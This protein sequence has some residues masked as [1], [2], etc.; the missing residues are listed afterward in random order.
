MPHLHFKRTRYKT[1]SQNASNRIEYI[2]GQSQ[3]Q[4][5][6]SQRPG[7]EDLV[8]V[9]THNLP[10]WAASAHVYFQAAEQYE[11]ANGVAFEEFK[12]TLPVELTTDQNKALAE[13][14]IKV[15][16]GDRLPC[17]Y[18]FHNPKT[19][20]EARDQPHLHLLISGRMT[21]STDEY[22]R[23]VAQHFK[24]WNGKEPGQ[25]GAQKDPAMNVY[26]ATK[27]H[28][29]M[30]SD[31]LNVHLERHGVAARVHP[32]S[33]ERRG[34]ERKPEPKL[35]PSESRD[36]RDKRE[37]SETMAEVLKIRE[38]KVKDRAKESNNAYA[39]WEQRKAE[40]GLTR[41]MEAPVKLAVLKAARSA[42]VT[43]T[44]VRTAKDTEASVEP[45]DAPRSVQARR[46]RAQARAWQSVEAGMAGL[47]RQ[48]EALGE[49]EGQSP[50]GRVR[51]FDRREEQGLGW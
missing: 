2:T 27:L 47:L 16:A 11:R 51:L 20:D 14:L 9:A 35:L 34:I 17:T 33:L 40:L 6:Y 12:I 31:V 10:A 39:Y 19:L 36:Y 26:H 29:L 49:D 23:P 44:P 43:V 30:I 15:I 46:E 5:E 13:D 24:R 45:A 37:V 42:H 21:G 48:V 1:G 4:I 8:H 18:A 38:A 25:G 3:K 41:D 50:G 32:D 7:R 22:Q 28:R